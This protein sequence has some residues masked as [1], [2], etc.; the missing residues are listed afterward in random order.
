[1]MLLSRLL[2]FIG[3]TT[4]MSSNSCFQFLFPPQMTTTLRQPP[5]PLIAAY[6]EP[7]PHHIS[8]NN[9]DDDTTTN[10]YYNYYANNPSVFG[11]ILNG[12]IPSRTYLEST[13]LLAFRDR[14]PKAPL[15][16]LVIPKRFIKTV[17]SLRG[18]TITN[19]NHHHHHGD[20]IIDECHGD[21]IQ[22]DHNNND[23]DDNDDDDIQLVQN[24]R[25]MG[26]DLLKQQ[27]PDALATND[28]ILCFHIPPFNSVDHLHLHVLAPA[29]EMNWIYRE[30]KYK[31]GARWCT[32]DLDVI[33]RLK[34]GL[35]AV[36]YK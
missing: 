2:A 9:Y 16:A 28:Y 6:H 3:G 33:E 17:Y 24:M 11:R 35:P 21:R 13:E 29:S 36:A 25:Q 15:H 7:P 32:S 26:L 27:Q 18:K 5:P 14:S 1:M 19:N 34:K 4:V 12:E 22:D 23:H 10:N 30:I 31:C 20:D 8:H